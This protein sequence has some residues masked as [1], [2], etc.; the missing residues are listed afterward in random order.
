VADDDF[1]DSLLSGA[2]EFCRLKNYRNVLSISGLFFD[3]CATW[4]IMPKMPNVAI[5]TVRQPLADLAEPLCDTG[6]F[7]NRRA[8]T[9]HLMYRVIVHVSDGKEATY[10]FLED[11]LQDARRLSEEIAQKGFWLEDRDPAIFIPASRVSLVQ[12]LP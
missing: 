5:P 12:V 11:S 10:E 1:V 6:K 9:E 2:A 7:R 4:T 3:R 8:A